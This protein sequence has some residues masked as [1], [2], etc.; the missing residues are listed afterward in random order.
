RGDIYSGLQ[1]ASWSEADRVYAHK[2]L[3][4]LSGLYGALRACDGIM[5]YR[6]EMGYKLPGGESMYVFWGDKL[7]RIIQP[8]TK[9][10]INLSAAEY[11]KALLPYARTSVITP[12]FM[13]ISPRTSVPTF[14]TVH[15]KIARGAFAGWLIRERIDT[16]QDMHAFGDLGYSYDANSSTP[17]QPVF[18]CQKF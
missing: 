5:P 1:V 7:A 2:H 17:E 8:E 14:V 4:I 3:I 18:V 12:K 6:L 11:T 13:T 10:L 9:Y 16:P 15:A